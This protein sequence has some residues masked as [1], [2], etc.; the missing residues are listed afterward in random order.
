MHVTEPLPGDKRARLVF[1]LDWRAYTVKGASAE[2]RRYADDFG[3]THYI[4]I[5]VAGEMIGGFGTPDP[6]ETRGARLYAGAAR[7]ALNERI[8]ARPAALILLQDGQL[9]HL[10]FVVR[11]A[12]RRDEVLSLEDARNRQHDIEQECLRTNLKLTVFG[13]GASIAEL[14]E[15]FHASELLGPKKAG[16]F[17]RLPISIP[18][19]LPLGVI[20]LA[21]VVGGGK[22]MDLFSPAKAHVDTWEERYQKAVGGEFRTPRPLASQLATQLLVLSGPTE[23][24][25]KG[26]Q[27]EHEDCGTHGNC[28]VSYLRAGGTFAGF[29]ESATADMRPLSFSADG[30]HL[31]TK[32]MQ[33]PKAASVRFA[34]AKKWPSLQEMTKLLQ[35]PAQRLSVKPFELDSYGYK[36]IIDP[37]PRPIL[38]VPAGEARHGAILKVGTWEIDGYRWQTPLLSR[39][40]SNMALESLVETLQTK[41]GKD[42]AAGMK[43]IAKGKYY[44]LE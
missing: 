12:V 21:L 42:G 39:L 34:D 22:V 23:V 8:K 7:I 19:V 43:F 3:A 14:D 27:V 4:E 13:S 24:I 5:K 16:R 35:T 18:T 11:G 40:P 38:A 26:W 10:V 15:P 9:V 30:Q 25:R 31:T 28:A 1:G 33:I 17:S 41:A 6:V 36:V 20:V 37:A 2:R 29:E 32:G 44:V